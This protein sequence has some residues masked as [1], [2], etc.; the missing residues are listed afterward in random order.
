MDVRTWASS[1]S[2][3]NHHY[4][5]SFAS[6]IQL[7]HRP[8]TKPFNCSYKGAYRPITAR[9][10]SSLRCCIP[11]GE[12]VLCWL[13]WCILTIHGHSMHAPLFF[14]NRQQLTTIQLIYKMSISTASLDSW[15]LSSCDSGM[16]Q[17]ATPRSKKSLTQATRHQDTLQ[18]STAVRE[19]WV[20]ELNGR[21]HTSSD[22]A[23]D[24][25]AIYVPSSSDPPPRDIHD[26]IFSG[27][28]PTAGREKE[29]YPLLVRNTSNFSSSLP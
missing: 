13:G 29:M 18:G 16:S 17:E 2:K 6:V 3:P 26:D 7:I 14:L 11:S 28:K 24:Y 22:S 5:Y 8:I 27:W 9:F 15:A 21:I 1:L 20:E 25:V 23:D 4:S 19:A 10:T 12:L